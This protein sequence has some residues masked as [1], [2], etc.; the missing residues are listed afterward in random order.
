[1]NVRIEQAKEVVRRAKADYVNRLKQA[2]SLL[3]VVAAQDPADI[4]A[5]LAV[6]DSYGDV[7]FDKAVLAPLTQP[8]RAAA[9]EPAA[10]IEQTVDVTEE[11][12]KNVFK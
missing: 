6:Q 9:P 4:D 5:A 12:L 11:D 7:A 10:T 2:E 8:A 1:M 3:K